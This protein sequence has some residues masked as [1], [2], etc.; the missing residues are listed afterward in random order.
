MVTQLWIWNENLKSCLLDGVRLEIKL[1][2]LVLVA[3]RGK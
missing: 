2:E 1:Q 3:Q